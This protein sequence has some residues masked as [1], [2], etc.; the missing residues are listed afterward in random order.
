MGP[1]AHLVGAFSFFHISII[2]NID[3]VFFTYTLNEGYS[4]FRGLLQKITTNSV[5]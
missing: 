4:S 3:S 2:V 5:D 1:E